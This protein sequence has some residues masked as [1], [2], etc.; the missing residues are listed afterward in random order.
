MNWVRYPIGINSRDTSEIW[1]C[2]LLA[3]VLG[4][5]YDVVRSIFHIFSLTN[6]KYMYI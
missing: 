5:V 6:G 4:Y 1:N 2:L 3:L